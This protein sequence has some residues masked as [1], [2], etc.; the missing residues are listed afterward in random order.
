MEQ[1]RGFFKKIIELIKKPEMR[2]LPGQLAF[3]LV[4]S[5]IPIIALIGTIATTLSVSADTITLTIGESVPKEIAN[6]LNEFIKGQGLNFNIT[7]FF[8][9]AFFS[10][11][12]LFLLL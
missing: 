8:L 3:F 12:E 4:I 6:M 11:P 9:S 5:I 1:A 10:P 7:I 2:I